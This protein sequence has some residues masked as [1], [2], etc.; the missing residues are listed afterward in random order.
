ME[1]SALNNDSSHGA[2]FGDY[3]L[4]ADE[5]QELQRLYASLKQI[6]GTVESEKLR[7][8]IER[9]NET[10]SRSSIEDKIVDLAI[11]LES[12]LLHGIKD[13]LNLRLALRGARLLRDKADARE[14]FRTLR[15]MY[16]VR[17][18]IVHSGARMNA[19]QFPGSRRP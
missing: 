8:P 3:Q 12:T 11:A 14:T 6:E 2:S 4:L 18:E 9:F 1:T 15:A 7:L 13:E 17:S 19:E 16:K 5:E 10:Y